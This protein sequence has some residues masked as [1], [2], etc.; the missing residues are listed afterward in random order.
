MDSLDM[1]GF[2]SAST[3]VEMRSL[4]GD[5]LVESLK[6]RRVYN[7]ADPTGTLLYGS[8]IRIPEIQSFVG[9]RLGLSRAVATVDVFPGGSPQRMDS[10]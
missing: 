6:V 7:G 9:Q 1:A 2:G 10:G 3:V 4:A 5:V 8:L